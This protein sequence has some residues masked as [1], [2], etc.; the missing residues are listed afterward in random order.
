MPITEL[1]SDTLKELDLSHSGMG[2]TETI[3]I[4]ELVKGSA[5]L[6]KLNLS[7]NDI[8]DEG[9]IA[10]SKCLEVNSSLLELTLI[11]CKISTEGGTALAKGVAANRALQKL[12]MQWDLGDE[13]K[14]RSFVCRTTREGF[15]ISFRSELENLS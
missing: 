8:K 11:S 13:V 1:R 2:P 10:L 7:Y 9:V 15:E 12:V 6:S 3:V 5:S 14:T 4:A